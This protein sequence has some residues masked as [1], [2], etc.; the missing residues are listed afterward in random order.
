MMAIS[1]NGIGN[2]DIKTDNTSKSQKDDN[3]A[4]DAFASLLNMT[5]VKADTNTDYK[6]DKSVVATDTKIKADKYTTSM[7]G[8][9]S[10]KTVTDKD[11]AADVISDIKNAIKDALGVSDDKLEKMLA[12]F[13]IDITD[14]LDVNTL[15]K[16]VLDVNNSTEIDLLIN[17]DLSNVLDD[18]TS[19]VMDI[20][21]DY[22]LEDVD[23]DE[24]IDTLK[25][26]TLPDMSD[27][28]QVIE[29]VIA[30]AEPEYDIDAIYEKVAK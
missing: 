3:K 21:K 2:I 6:S 30:D 28:T 26:F 12:D 15:K 22:S 16:F 18:I 11:V 8:T 29:T 5:S 9:Q 23:V 14:L 20:L 27:D 7:S 17:E 13:G 24:L 10:V 4:T 1:A 19:S 25:N